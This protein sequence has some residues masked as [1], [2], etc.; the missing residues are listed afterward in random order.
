LILG[1]D[2]PAASDP[3]RSGAKAAT[4]AAARRAGLPILPGFVVEAAASRR[5]LGIGAAALAER[6]S[7][8]ARLAV[9]ATPLDKTEEVVAAARAL[10]PTLA[11]RSS[12]PLE[13]GGAWAG[14]FTSYTG[15]TPEEVP[16]A[17][18]GCWASAFSVD[19]LGR[20]HRHG[21][22]PGSAPLAVLV[23]PSLDPSAAGV[24]EI[25]AEGGIRVEAVAGPP[26]PLLQGWARGLVATRVPGGEWDG[27]AAVTLAGRDALDEIAAALTTA[28]RR[29]GCDRCEWA[30]AGEAWVLQLGVVAR[31][32]STAGPH[33]ARTPADLVPAVQAAMSA[34]GAPGLDIHLA[35][36]VVLDH[37]ERRQGV[38]AAPGVGV[39]RRHHLRDPDV[40]PPPHA[41]ITAAQA[42]PVLS[43]AI[44]DAAGLVTGSGSPAAHLF[45]AARSL[46]V[47]AVCGVDLGPD[48]DLIVAVDGHS[49]VVATLPTYSE[50]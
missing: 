10:A 40:T 20:Q 30:V 45:E 35:A 38:P 2:D 44:W 1:L 12:S 19:A 15:V 48:P 22:E 26:A 49:G 18:V 13:G 28:K 24:A 41:V 7:G 11:V 50:P 9:H 27:A 43:Q 5:H 47:P 46:G 39:G 29:L 34:P 4:L 31:P 33:R 23:Q 32:G 3:T 36:A 17:V 16:K 37:G 21:I 8:G 14:A 25:T 6:G 42:V